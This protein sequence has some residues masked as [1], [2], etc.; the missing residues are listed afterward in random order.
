[1]KKKY[2][3]KKSAIIILISSLTILIA[4]TCFIISLLKTKSYS[5]EYNLDEYEIS[6]N[7]NSEKKYYYYEITNDKTKYNFIYQSEYLKEKK[8]IKEIKEYNDEKYTCITIRSDYITSYPMCTYQKKLI[9][10]HLVSEKMQE[11]I[12]DY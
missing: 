5:V 4:L 6:E 11:K 12:A 1:M 10:Y 2:R 9:D 3:L 8:L 7:Y